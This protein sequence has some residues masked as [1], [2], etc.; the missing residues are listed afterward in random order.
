MLAI[1]ILVRCERVFLTP[2]S[3]RADRGGKYSTYYDGP[4]GYFAS[5]L[6]KKA[7][8]RMRTCSMDSVDYMKWFSEGVHGIIVING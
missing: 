6:T 1:C 8:K 5:R 3:P 7:K 2:Q 4:A